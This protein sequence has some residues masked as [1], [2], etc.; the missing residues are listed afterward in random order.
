MMMRFVGGIVQSQGIIVVQGPSSAAAPA[1]VPMVVLISGSTFLSGAAVK[2]TGSYPPY[3]NITITHNA[4]TSAAHS[5]DLGV[6]SNFVTV[7]AFIDTVPIVLGEG[8]AISAQYNNISTNS[9]AANPH[10]V[11]FVVSSITFNKGSSAS[12]RGNT[13]RTH[14]EAGGGNTWIIF[15]DINPT[16]YVIGNTERTTF[17]FL[18]GGAWLFEKNNIYITTDVENAFF[19]HSPFITS[20]DG[21]IYSVSRNYILVSPSPDTSKGEN[22][23]MS[24]STITNATNFLFLMDCNTFDGYGRHSAM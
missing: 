14:G 10:S 17:L 8:A 23:L 24:M 21:G 12:T 5:I 1:K 9:S 3:S 15:F 2:I 22:L 18:G 16:A 19:G 6:A 11:P 4:F 7:M 20:P 13:V